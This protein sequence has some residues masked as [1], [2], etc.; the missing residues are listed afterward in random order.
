MVRKMLNF[1]SVF[2]YVTRSKCSVVTSE[3]L[4]QHLGDRVPIIQPILQH[5]QLSL[6]RLGVLTTWGE[7]VVGR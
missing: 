4:Q 5:H 2:P 6:A 7:E 1:L 3:W